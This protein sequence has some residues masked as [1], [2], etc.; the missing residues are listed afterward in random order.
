MTY[1][2]DQD[3]R[4]I[5]LPA[6][7]NLNFAHVVE[8]FLQNGGCSV[9]IGETR[10]EYV[11]RAMSNERLAAETPA[12]FQAFVEK[13]KACCPDLIVAVDQEMGGI[14]RLQGL[15][16]ALPELADANKLTDDALA[17]R[18]FL[19]AQAARRLGVS[20]FLAPIADVVDGQNPWL[21]NRTMG[22]D[23]QTV[24]RLVSAYVKGVQRAGITAV[25]KHFPGFN[26]LD[27]DPA[28][29]DVSLQTAP[30]RILANALPFAA[31][32][33]AGTKAIMTGPAPVVALDGTNAASTS[34]TVIALLR[35]QFG[36]DGLI[37]SDDLDAPATMRGNSLLETAVASLTAGA[38]LL[39]VAGGPH[40]EALC[41]GVVA[42]VR[43]G[44][45]SAGRLA[46]AAARVRKNA[47]G[48]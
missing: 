22:P 48:H 14:R 25:T 2:L 28:L 46:D 37:V 45:L 12:L 36:F 31:A 6:F 30:D 43:R 38:D 29:V 33:A 41:D 19:T 20:M 27:A 21:R 4:A 5:L 10:A 23:A 32:I 34:A 3:A 42:A 26:D 17:E 9:L 1:S 8:P 13:L 39:L 44:T 24:S 18:C 15:V 7:D 16:P 11:S 40:I 47:A 35:G